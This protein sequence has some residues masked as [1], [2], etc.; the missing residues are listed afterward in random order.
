MPKPKAIDPG[1]SKNIS[2]PESV[3]S[4]VDARLFS[5][6]EARVPHGA[7]SRLITMLLR[8]WLEKLPMVEVCTSP[9]EE[10]LKELDS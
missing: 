1:I 6:T 8:Q 5:A 4:Q 3:V 10:M 9:T 2:I 7:Y